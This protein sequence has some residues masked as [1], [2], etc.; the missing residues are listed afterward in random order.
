MWRNDSL[1]TGCL[2]ESVTFLTISEAFW[3]P[4]GCRHFFPSQAI[5]LC[6]WVEHLKK[7][8]KMRGHFRRYIHATL[9]ANS[10]AYLL[11][12][13]KW[14]K[15]QN[16]FILIQKIICISLTYYLYKMVHL[17]FFYDNLKYIRT[18][19]GPEL[20]IYHI[21]VFLHSFK[22]ISM[23]EIAF[24]QITFRWNEPLEKKSPD[25]LSPKGM[26]YYNC[27]NDE[28]HLLAVF[29]RKW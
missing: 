2:K 16:W 6:G 19:P 17:N 27:S 13:E 21:F 18:L 12:T 10:V 14:H 22:K 15:S 5:L 1:I 28:G 9:W 7:I 23:F 8:A 29:D 26:Y 11:E 3:Q 25:G 20:F 4:V 24:F